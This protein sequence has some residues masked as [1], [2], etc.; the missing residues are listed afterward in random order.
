MKEMS[1]RRMQGTSGYISYFGSNEGKRTRYSCDYY[2]REAR[3][4]VREKKIHGCLNP[5]WCKYFTEIGSIEQKQKAK[6][7][8]SKSLEAFQKSKANPKP[9]KYSRVGSKV[10]VKNLTTKEIIECTIVEG[11]QENKNKG[12]ISKT[13]PLGRALLYRLKGDVV[14]VKVRKEL[15]K[16]E[17]LRIE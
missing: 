14:E 7:K 17:I 2:N 6:K 12:N 4:C 3:C 13:S 16:Y 11:N 10:K 5:E 1:L 9:S 15:I 8:K